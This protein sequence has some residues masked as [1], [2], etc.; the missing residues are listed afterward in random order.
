MIFL[1]VYTLISLSLILS[2][3]ANAGV[4]SGMAVLTIVL[5]AFCSGAGLRASFYYGYQQISAATMATMVCMAIATWLGQG[6]TAQVFGVELTGGLWGWIGF[7]ASFVAN[8]GHSRKF[9]ALKSV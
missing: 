8:P 9:T 6:F 3:W 7:S 5:V 2:A 1:I 4:G